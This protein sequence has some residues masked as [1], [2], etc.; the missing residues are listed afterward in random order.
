MAFTINR[1]LTFALLPAIVLAV[2]VTSL[3][4]AA[5][6]AITSPSPGILVT[7]GQT[8]SVTV[9]PGTGT[10]LQQVMAGISPL[11]QIP[12]VV[13][14]PPYQFFVTVPSGLIGIVSVTA[15]ALDTLGNTLQ[16]SVNVVVK[17]VASATSIQVTPKRLV[18]SGVDGQLRSVSVSAAFQDGTSGYVTTSPDT[19]Y[20]LSNSKVAVV[21]SIGQVQAVAPGL[22]N[23]TITYSGF[24][25]TVPLSV[26]VFTLKGDLNGDG[27]VD[28]NDIQMLL[29][30]L[31]TASTGPGDPRD[32]NNDGKID[33]LESRIMVT[34]CSRPACATH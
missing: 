17:P 24:T 21:N 29:K 16:A 5:S 11:N 30:A 33:A 8:I 23:L 6:I 22:A 10:V 13:H 26:G 20:G 14:T 34:L 12:Q 32:L 19:Q 2:G 4:R 27:A 15:L 7:P 31:N 9:Q 25:T 1:R 3:S 18:F 28:Q